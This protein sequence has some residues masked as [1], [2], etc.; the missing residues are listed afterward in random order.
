MTWLTTGEEIPQGVPVFHS[1]YGS[2]DY[3]SV[4][5]W[6]HRDCGA[7]CG[8]VVIPAH[9]LTH[10]YRAACCRCGTRHVPQR[11]PAYGW[12]TVTTDSTPETMEHVIDPFSTTMPRTFRSYFSQSIA[13]A[14]SG[15]SRAERKSRSAVFRVTLRAAVP[16]AP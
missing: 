3:A 11:S 8:D 5:V 7:A 10:G 16:E 4:P 2:A 9:V 6:S 15:E 1:N 13:T 12:P 14:R